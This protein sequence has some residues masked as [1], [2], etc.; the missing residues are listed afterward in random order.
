MKTVLMRIL[1]DIRV[2][3]GDEFDKNFERQSF[4]TQAWSRRRSPIRPGGHL[5]VDSGALRRSVSSRSDGN[6]VTF[7]SDLPYASIHNDGGNIKVTAR[8]KRYFW[9]RYY[10]AQGGFGRK[11]NGELRDNK[12]NRQLGS[13]AEFWKALALIKEGK[14]IKI[15]KRQFIGMSPEVEREVREIIEDNLTDYFERMDLKK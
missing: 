9:A 15:P 2:G 1:R 7:Y 12:K 8:M 6:S 10:E 3:I 13:E 5:L 4:F 14:V 11:R